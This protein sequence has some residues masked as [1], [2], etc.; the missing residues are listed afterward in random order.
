MRNFPGIV[1]QVL[2]LTNDGNQLIPLNLPETFSYNT[3]GLPNDFDFNNPLGDFYTFN[4]SIFE[5]SAQPLYISKSEGS[6]EVPQP[7][8]AL[9]LGAGLLGLGVLG[10]YRRNIAPENHTNDYQ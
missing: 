3:S 6:S 10:A 7:G 5:T 4:T 9:L 8:T 2:K 1:S